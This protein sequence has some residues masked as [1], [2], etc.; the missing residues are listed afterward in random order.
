MVR[1][2][3]FYIIIIIEIQVEYHTQIKI[4]LRP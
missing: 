2:V 4:A 3:E 1:D